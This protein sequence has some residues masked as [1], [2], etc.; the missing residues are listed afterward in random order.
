MIRRGL[1]RMALSVTA[2]SKYIQAQHL[3]ELHSLT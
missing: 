3:W 1:S 2:D